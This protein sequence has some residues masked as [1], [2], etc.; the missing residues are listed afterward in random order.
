MHLTGILSLFQNRDRLPS[1]QRG[2]CWDDGELELDQQASA[3]FLS[4]LAA[5]N[6]KKD[7]QGTKKQLQYTLKQKFHSLNLSTMTYSNGN[8]FK[9]IHFKQFL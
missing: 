8:T 9:R 1:H 4:K 5:D 2:G 3:I 6:Q 7:Q